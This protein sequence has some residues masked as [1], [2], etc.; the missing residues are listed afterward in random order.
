MY[1]WN[2]IKDTQGKLPCYSR[3]KYKVQKRNNENSVAV[4]RELWRIKKIDPETI[5][6]H[7]DYFNLVDLLRT[8]G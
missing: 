3:K 5:T 4:I 7:I 1:I 8:K 6:D 2:K